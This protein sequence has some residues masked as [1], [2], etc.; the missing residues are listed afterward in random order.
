MSDMRPALHGAGAAGRLKPRAG[1]PAPG[2]FPKRGAGSAQTPSA[3]GVFCVALSDPDLRASLD[4]IPNRSRAGAFVFFFFVGDATAKNQDD[5]RLVELAADPSPRLRALAS[6][7][8][9]LR[10]E[11]AA[12]AEGLLCAGEEN[13]EPIAPLVLWYGVEPLAGRQA[14][15]CRAL[16][17]KA[18]IP[19]VRRFLLDGC[20][21]GTPGSR[22]S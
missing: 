3:Y 13:D 2:R 9:R 4:P 22:F 6:G 11:R 8:Q 1:P 7:L 10:C 21:C 14:S 12:M 17:A 15:P 20:D 5:H 18:R 19:L 16:L